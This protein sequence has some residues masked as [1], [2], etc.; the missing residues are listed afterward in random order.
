MTFEKN[1]LF[2]NFLLKCNA[3][4]QPK[5][6]HINIMLTFHKYSFIFKMNDTFYSL[7]GTAGQRWPDYIGPKR[8]KKTSLSNQ[9][10]L[11]PF[12]LKVARSGIFLILYGH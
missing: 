5:G 9:P 3:C 7:E 11:S 6:I 8:E 10:S 2:S 1:F 12:S 4:M